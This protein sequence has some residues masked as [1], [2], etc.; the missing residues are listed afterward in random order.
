MPKKVKAKKV[1][2]DMSGG[3][4]DIQPPTR[5]FGREAK[6]PNSTFPPARLIF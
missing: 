6:I 1:K 3:R 5:K 2:L 4:G